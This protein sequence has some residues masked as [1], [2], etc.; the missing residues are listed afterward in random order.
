[1]LVLV[2]PCCHHE[3]HGDADLGVCWPVQVAV[4]FGPVG[5]G[6]E[7]FVRQGVEKRALQDD[8]ALLGPGWMR[9]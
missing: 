8:Q 6:G 2:L 1:M 7:G 3:V 9:A 5:E 4:G